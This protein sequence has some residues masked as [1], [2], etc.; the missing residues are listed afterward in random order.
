M[1]REHP[2]LKGKITGVRK[3]NKVTFG[4]IHNPTAFNGFRGR[5]PAKVFV[6]DKALDGAQMKEGMSIA[7]DMRNSQDTRHPNKLEAYN[8]MELHG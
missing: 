8:V 6:T 5:C 4:F 3:G 1:S 7:F 2:T